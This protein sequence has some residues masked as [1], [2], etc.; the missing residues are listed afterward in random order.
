MTAPPK[1]RWDKFGVFMQPLGGL[2]TAISVAVV[3]LAGSRV[4]E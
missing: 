4:I 2:L 3:G 1:D